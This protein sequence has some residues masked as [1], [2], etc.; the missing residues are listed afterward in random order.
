MTDIDCRSSLHCLIGNPFIKISQPLE[1][2]IFK[3]YNNWRKGKRFIT[4]T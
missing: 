2:F 4:S 1:E 3:Q